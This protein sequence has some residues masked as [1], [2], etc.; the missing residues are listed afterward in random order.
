MKTYCKIKENNMNFINAMVKEIENF[1]R[2]EK[3]KSENEKVDQEYKSLYNDLFSK[4][5]ELF[6]KTF[7]VKMESEGLNWKEEREDII[8][9]HGNIP[10]VKIS[11]D[12]YKKRNLE[13]ALSV[14]STGKTCLYKDGYFSSVKEGIKANFD[15]SYKSSSIKEEKFTIDYN[16]STKEKIEDAIK[17]LQSVNFD[18]EIIICVRDSKMG[19]EY[20]SKHPYKDKSIIYE[21]I[22]CDDA[23]EAI[24][25][26]CNSIYDKNCK[27]S[28]DNHAN[29]LNPNNSEY[30][31]V[32]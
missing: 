26:V 15:I 6:I 14:N 17:K 1:K 4:K 5:A 29:Q 27:A 20:D 9:L 11:K 18:S 25:S 30:W 32:R 21:G 23:I 10:L 28:L 3:I 22:S 16:V 7:I 8:F 2:N 31:H 19:H 12:F 24:Y 13:I